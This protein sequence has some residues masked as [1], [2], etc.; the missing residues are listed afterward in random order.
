M[1]GSGK[2][3]FDVFPTPMAKNNMK[4]RMNTAQKGHD[5]LEKKAEVLEIRFRKVGKEIIQTK[6]VIGDVFRDAAILLAEARY[7]SGDFNQMV[8]NGI[9]TARLKVVN[10]MENVAGIKLTNFKLL[11]DGSDLFALTGLAKGGEKLLSLKQTY[12]HAVEILVELATLQTTF[13]VLDENIKSINRRVNALDQAYIPKCKRTLQYIEEE[14]D[15]R[16]RQEFFRLKKI[17]D[18]KKRIMEE[19]KELREKMEKKKRER[20]G[21]N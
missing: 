4:N 8:L 12:T 5:I 7:V 20:E 16:E 21:E 1:A 13:Q 3:I 9:E 18:I 10:K 17:K 11:T 19:K 15:D 2:D 14:I 6:S